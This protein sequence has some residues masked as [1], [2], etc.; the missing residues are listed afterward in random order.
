MTRQ[1]RYFFSRPRKFLLS[2]PQG[3]VSSCETW[4]GYLL[5]PKRPGP[6]HVSVLPPGADPPVTPR[7]GGS[8]P[9][10]PPGDPPAEPA[11]RPPPRSSVA[12]PPGAD[13]PATPRTAG[14]RPPSPP[15]DPPAEPADRPRPRSSIALPPGA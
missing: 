13:P 3:G 9:P 12:L 10:S 14:S 15:G 4:H 8:R 5:S 6:C 1:G 2:A 7:T 11:D